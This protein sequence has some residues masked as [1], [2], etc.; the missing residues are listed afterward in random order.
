MT[1]P[2]RFKVQLRPGSYGSEHEN[3]LLRQVDGKTVTL[4]EDLG[5]DLFRT[6][7]RL[8]GEPPD[9]DYANNGYLV[10]MPSK[11]GSWKV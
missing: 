1:L 5:R 3:D 8:A 10:V 6:D 11:D 9:S 2:C 7:F 4:V